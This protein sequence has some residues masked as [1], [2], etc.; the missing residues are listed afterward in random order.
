MNKSLRCNLS[1]NIKKRNLSEG[2]KRSNSAQKLNVLNNSK[3]S[4]HSDYNNFENENTTDDDES[5]IK[6]EA[7][8]LIDKTRK[9][10]EDLSLVKIENFKKGNNKKSNNLAN[11]NY[12]NNISSNLNE[13]SSQKL[14]LKNKQ[15]KLLERELKEKTNQLKMA[16]EKLN[17]KNEEIKK[18]NEALTNE[19]SNN[20]RADNIKLQRKIFALEKANEENKKTYEKMID[21]FKNK[22]NNANNKNNENLNEI[23]EIQRKNH[24][25]EEDNRKLQKIINEKTNLSN[26]LKEKNDIEKK[27]NEKK[28]IEIEDLKMNLSN[29]IVI[30]KTLFAKETDFYENRKTFL[31]NFERLMN[32]ENQYNNLLGSTYSSSQNIDLGYDRERMN[33]NNINDLFSNK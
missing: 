28:D 29:L 32:S 15:I 25:L 11:I 6:K 14:I 21:D 3:I 9:M 24:L 13:D 20:L 8:E 31:D 22:I 27:V 23:K 17:S 26:Q 10:M 30:L 33:D 7:K 12:Q 19:R 16:Q 1:S 18:I 4:K 5:K 2:S